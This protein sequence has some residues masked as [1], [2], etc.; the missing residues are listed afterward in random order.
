[1][2][3]LTLLPTERTY[4]VFDWET[5]QYDYQYP[6]ATVH[7]LQGASGNRENNDGF[8]SQVPDWSVSRSSEV[9]FALMKVT[10]TQI[11]WSYWAS[12]FY[13]DGGPY[14]IDPGMILTQWR[15]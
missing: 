14:I 1:M 7:I 2:P 13:T 10:K 4:P 6:N 11:Q 15:S 8:P 12:R 9:G 3:I 5:V